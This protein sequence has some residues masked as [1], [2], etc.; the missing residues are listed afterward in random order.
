ME[1]TTLA[2]EMLEIPDDTGALSEEEIKKA[3]EGPQYLLDISAAWLVLA[4]EATVHTKAPGEGSKSDSRGNYEI[5][6]RVAA[7]RD[8][9]DVSS[10]IKSAQLF[11]RMTLPVDH[12]GFVT[13]DGTPHK[14]P[15]W[16]HPHCA[17]RLSALFP[18]E[19]AGWPTKQSD[20]TFTVNGQAI[21]KKE[22]ND[23]KYAAVRSVNELVRKQ[24]V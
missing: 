14:A 16:A 20:G 4:A 15:A 19:C 17:E 5:K 9:N 24:K 22:I 23:R 3:A 7:L 12:K 8:P 18:Q 1:E 11:D 6:F 10:A 2:P 13:V 21:D